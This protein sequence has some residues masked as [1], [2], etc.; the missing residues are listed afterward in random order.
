V[1]D[2]EETHEDFD[3]ARAEDEYPQCPVCGE[4]ID[5]CLGH[6]PTA[7]DLDELDEKDPETELDRLY[8]EQTGRLDPQG[9]PIG[10][11]PRIRR[12]P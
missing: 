3:W 4:P 5:Y 2:L 11:R 6:G 8:Y 9:P 10:W 7:E 1:S 12:E